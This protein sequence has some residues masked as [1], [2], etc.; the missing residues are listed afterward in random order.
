MITGRRN[1]SR[2]RRQLLSADDGWQLSDLIPWG[3][4]GG[5]L[6]GGGL[7]GIWLDSLFQREQQEAQEEQLK[8]LLTIALP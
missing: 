2:H 4:L 3:E 6:I 8:K 5:I 7:L 1:H